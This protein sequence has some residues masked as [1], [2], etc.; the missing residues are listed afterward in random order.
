MI[1]IQIAQL[2]CTHTW[3]KVYEHGM[4]LPM[5]LYKKK[6][7]EICIVRHSSLSSAKE[8]GIKAVNSH[9]HKCGFMNSTIHSCY[10]V[11][12]L[13]TSSM[14]ENKWVIRC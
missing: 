10:T 1:N 9:M 2:Y 13:I 11:R 6:V 12:H 14:K 4:Q 5:E 8:N 7:K 3:Y